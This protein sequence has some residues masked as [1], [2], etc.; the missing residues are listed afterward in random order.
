MKRLILISAFAIIMTSLFLSSCK[1]EKK[2]ELPKESV[3]VVVADFEKEEL[4]EKFGTDEIYIVKTIMT[5]PNGNTD[6]GLYIF[7]THY[8]LSDGTWKTDEYSYKYKLI[9]TGRLNNAV[10]D[11]TYYILSNRPDIS[12]EE[13]WKASGLSSNIEDYFKPEDAII[14]AFE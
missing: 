9:V 12:F 2:K 11:S 1:E 14:V 7:K 4:D 13:A 10:K 6:D 3:T 8:Q 5:S